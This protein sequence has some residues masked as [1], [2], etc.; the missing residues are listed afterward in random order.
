MAGG[1]NI[2]I[3]ADASVFSRAVKSG[4]I[5]PLEDASDALDD[6]NDVS[7]SG[8]ESEL[9]GAERQ[10]DDIG[11][12]GKNAGDDVEKGMRD[13]ER[14]ADKAGDAGKHAG[15]DIERGMKDAQRQTNLTADDYK[16]MSAKVKAETEKIKTANK[17]AFDKS[18]DTTGEFKEEALS[19]FSEVTSSFQGDMTSIT[20]L[21]QGTFGGLASM[22]GP[23]SLVFGGIAVAV[24]LIGQALTQSGEDTEEFKEKIAELADTKIGDLF[25]QYEDSGDDLSRGLRKWAT[26]ADSFGGSL[27]DLE[28]NTKT[29]GLEFGDLADAIG[30]QSVPKMK[31]MRTE[32][33]AQI[34]SLDRQA[35]A[36]RGAGN[37]TSALSKKFGE[38]S[39]A[40]RAVRK[41]LDDN[42]KVND[43]YEKTLRGVAKAQGLTVAQYR[44]SLEATKEYD[45]ATQAL[46]DTLSTTLADA[47]ESS[48]EAIDNTAEN[49]SK[50]I[51]GMQARTD[52]A[53]QY[54]SNIQAIGE[55]L[56]DD[57]FNF[58][59]EQ[60]PGFSQEIAT[61]LSAT[62]EQQ[63]A[64]EAGWKID[65][66]VSGDTTDLDK[67]TDAK[68]KEKKKG[69]TSEVQGD[70][71]DL[72]KKVSQKAKEKNDGPT[73]KIRADTSLVD[74][75]LESLKGK[76]VSGPTVQF[77]VDASSV[78]G[79]ISRLQN[80]VIRVPVKAVDG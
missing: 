15:D 37:G 18:S 52:A 4:V 21:A 76:K 54:Q 56:P 22:G 79:V 75:A 62:P 72:D 67:T 44:A 41:Q 77:Q 14:A 65:A 55:Q 6:L 16:A 40:A 1:F 61:Y 26:D 74:K 33:E 66:Q 57:L 19:N 64:I 7:T 8:L 69:P 20:D 45:D 38:Q 73:S 58:V 80:T 43:Q 53:L 9:K 17:E 27:S 48:S 78:N 35:A 11:K 71:S 60:G 34:K 24:G 51:A 13:V 59:R 39:D 36:Q 5:D 10:L 70:T 28:K 12:A 63:A 47:A 29:A 42:L 31:A 46:A 68:G 2:Q 32:V 25:S 49:A 50:Y 30:T 3:A 23:A